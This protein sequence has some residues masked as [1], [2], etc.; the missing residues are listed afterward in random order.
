MPF[1]EVE[2]ITLLTDH[3]EF[4]NR[5]FWDNSVVTKAPK[6]GWPSITQSTMANLNKTDAVIDLLRHM[7]YVDFVEPD[8]AYGKHVIMK[9]TR[10]QDYHSDAMQKRIRDG[11]LEYYVEP[12]GDPLPPSCISFGNSNGRN[13]YNLV[14]NTA[15]G[16]VY[17][18]DPS[19]QHD[20]PAPELNA[21][22]QERYAGDE[23]ERW[24]E[25]FNVY[26]PR[27]FFA[28]CKQR[29]RELRWIGLQTDIV[30]AVPMY[31]ELDDADDEFKSLVR[32]MKRAGWPGGGQGRDWDREAFQAALEVYSDEEG[33]D[34]EQ[35][36]TE[37]LDDTHVH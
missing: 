12:I 33:E 25:S 13:G 34:A 27:E 21:V 31:W 8:K 4:C 7:P 10:I 11:D 36:E 35:A 14:I 9:N 19:G 30:E 3:Y 37:G 2:F 1:D 22:V 16:Y 29:F 17:W 18:G 6:N 5:V 26:R 24:R 15:D 23:N 20:E 32:K 28:L